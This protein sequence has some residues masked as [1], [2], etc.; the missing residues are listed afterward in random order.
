MTSKDFEIRQVRHIWRN[1]ISFSTTRLQKQVRKWNWVIHRRIAKFFRMYTQILNYNTYML[2]SHRNMI[3][4]YDMTQHTQQQGG[5]NEELARGA[6]IKTISFGDAGVIRKMFIKKR[7]KQER[8][9][10]IAQKQS[11]LH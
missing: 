9:E 2:V 8:Q 11:K 5:D 1:R 4:I 6:W 3:S 10:M 7:E